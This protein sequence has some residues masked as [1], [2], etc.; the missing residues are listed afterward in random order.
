MTIPAKIAQKHMILHRTKKPSGMSRRTGTGV[1]LFAWLSLHAGVICA[2][3]TSSVESTDAATASAGAVDPSGD[4]RARAE[5]IKQF[6]RDEE[7][8]EYWRRELEQQD[9][10]QAIEQNQRDSAG[11]PP[12]VVRRMRRDIDEAKRAAN[13]PIKNSICR[14]ETIEYDPA[15]PEPIEIRVASNAPASIT[16]TDISG[17]TWPIASDASGDAEAFQAGPVEGANYSYEIYN[18]RP[19]AATI[20]LVRLQEQTTP[21]VL[22]ITGNETDHHCS[23]T[24]RL[25][26]YGPQAEISA[27]SLTPD[28]FGQLDDPVMF[29]VLRLSIPADARERKINGISDPGRAWVINNK[30]YIRANY[31]IESPPRAQ[32][33]GSN[34]LYVYRIDDP[35]QR[36]AWVKDARGQSTRISIGR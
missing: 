32:I 26:I 2:E 27:I 35:R 7:F 4:A 1:L 24:V 34:G 3:E 29:D 10:R 13:E 11:L 18:K 33:S 23:L 30:L 14:I 9:R 8:L 21:I 17:S 15:T 19:Y 25:P 5:A 31:F 12:E 22:R 16:F 20:N 6:L 36:T 28:A